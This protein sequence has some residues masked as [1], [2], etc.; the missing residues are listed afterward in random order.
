MTDL[1]ITDVRENKGDSA[2]LIDDGKTAVLCDTGFGFTGFAVADKIK[3]VL[4]DRPLDYILLTHSHYDHAL[5]SAYISKR[6]PS[7]KIVAGEYAA[8]IFSKPTA[9]AVMRDLDKKFAKKCGIEEYE[10]LADDLRVD[11]A[12]S[13]GD[14]ITAGAMQFEVIALPGHTKCSVGYF[15]KTHNLLVGCETLGV[16]GG[17]GIVVPSYL[18][19]YQMTLDSIEKIK[20]YDVKNIL[21]P[22]YGLLSADETAQYLRKSRVSAE[23]TADEIL[24]LLKKETPK[25]EIIEYF[26][27]KFYHGYIKEIYPTDAMELNTSITINLIEKELLKV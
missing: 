18:V 26:K 6:Y 25:P 3:A 4:G 17:D 1:K 19:G 10:D 11:I 13:D 16:Y 12:V 14:V 7:A 8:K 21:S 27:D 5:G 9:K 20:N 22:H 2:F 24:E 15:C 23:K